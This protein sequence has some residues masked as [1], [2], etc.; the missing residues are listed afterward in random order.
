MYL[1]SEIEIEKRKPKIGYGKWW[2]TCKRHPGRDGEILHQYFMRARTPLPAFTVPDNNT[3]AESY[4]GSPH[5]D[6]N[7]TWLK[8]VFRPPALFSGTLAFDGYAADDYAVSFPHANWK[9]VR[10]N[11][12]LRKTG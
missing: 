2:S 11:I 9:P 10:Q 3:K 8:S 6:V 5:R 12:K 1:C 7:D 4:D